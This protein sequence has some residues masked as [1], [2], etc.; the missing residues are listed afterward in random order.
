MEKPN[1]CYHCTNV[2][3]SSAGSWLY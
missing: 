1:M 2:K 3:L